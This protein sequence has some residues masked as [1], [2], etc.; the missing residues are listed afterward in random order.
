MAGQVPGRQTV[1]RSELWGAIQTLT[2]ADPKLAVRIGIDAAYV[3][4]GALKR[5]NLASGANGDL[6]CILFSIIDRREG[7]TELFKIKSHLEDKGPTAIQHSLIK[8]E[9]LV[10]NT[11]ADTVA[12][13]A[14]RRIQPD[15]SKVQPAK[16]GDSLGY[17]VTK[18][19]GIIQADIWRS[20]E[21]AGAIYEL[22]AIPAEA[23]IRQN[24]T[25]SPHTCWTQAG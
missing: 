6:W 7:T 18:R 20:K 14:A 22:E 16:F 2:R 21:N 4:N 13:A 3:T 9:D 8:F 15:L 25:I 11:M 23:E 5:G 19:L 1:P 17:S 12:E 10:G 24:V